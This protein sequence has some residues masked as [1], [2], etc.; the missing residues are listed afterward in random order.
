MS[1]KTVTSACCSTAAGAGKSTVVA[2]LA[3]AEA[4]F[5]PGTTVLLVSRSFRQA[6]ELFRKIKDFHF[7]VGEFLKHRRNAN[8][9]MLKGNSRIVCL[10]C[11]AETIRGFSGVDL[12]LLDEAA[13]IPDDLY[14]TVRPML[15]VSGGRMICLS[16][17]Y[18]K[19]GFYWDAWEHGGDD[20]ARIQIPAAE[21]PRIDPKFLE[22]ERRGL[23][24]SWYR[25]EYCCAFEALQGLVYPLFS[26]CLT[27]GPI[28]AGKRVGGID[29][30]Y[31][32]PFA[33]VWGVLD[34]NRV[35][36][37]TGEHYSR[38]KPLSFHAAHLPRDVTWYCDPAGATERSELR[39]AGFDIREGKNPLRPG[40]AAVN[41]RIESS[42]LFVRDCPNLLAEAGLYRYS[43]NPAER[44]AE[45][46]MDEHNHAL[47][48]L[49]YL[50]ATIDERHLVERP[51]KPAVVDDAARQAR[52]AKAQRDYLWN[53][54]AC[55]G[56]PIR[57]HLT[58]DYRIIP[59]DS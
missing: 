58:P 57:C 21:L 31:R 9:L 56:R 46:P 39:L 33:A 38:E 17:P 45:I 48:A 59:L 34:Q 11:K 49:R 54:P 3:L 19:R 26:R 10:P 28:P 47:A 23:G 50:I 8:E 53:N 1:S 15:A 25:Q 52:L 4:I 43:D 55:W 44:N 29:F 20:W 18:G 2:A 13:Q 32:N 41:A 16:T 5:V 22:S 51:A 35:L 27:T 42:R 7:K 6:S 36:W 12:L 14:R 24:E 30:G 40:I 37:L